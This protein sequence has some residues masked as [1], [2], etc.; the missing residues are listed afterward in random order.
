MNIEDREGALEAAANLSAS[1]VTA[2][3]Q[4]RMSEL[5]ESERKVARAL[6]ADYPVAGLDTVASLGALSGVS[7]PTVTR[8]AARLGYSGFPELQRALRR[9]VNNAMGSPL[10][11]YPSGSAN[12]APPSEG[13][14]RLVS[15]ALSG[16]TAEDMHRAS[17]ILAGRAP[18]SIVSGRFGRVIADYLHF[19]LMML[20]RSVW[21]A[22]AD[23]LQM[24]S[25]LV[26]MRRHHVLVLFDFRRYDEHNVDFAREA[27][28]RGATVILLTDVW[29]SPASDFANVVFA[30]PVATEGGFDSLVGPM[31]I[32][33]Q[34]IGSVAATLG[35]RGRGRLVEIEQLAGRLGR[36]P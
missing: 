6:L 13:A 8:F 3:I 36:R 21:V 33:D 16:V 19:H 30:S 1:T 12:S 28:S 32:C 26:S 31:A 27:R 2:R 9:E 24:S 5:R 35:E 11:Q 29:L 20:R 17:S 23:R 7:A 18:V 14:A 22:G 34:L 4:E 10:E 15:S 25:E